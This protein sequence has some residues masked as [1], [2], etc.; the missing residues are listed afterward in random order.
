MKISTQNHKRGVPM[1][2]QIELNFGETRI[3]AHFSLFLRVSTILPCHSRF[4][5]QNAY[6]LRKS[7][8]LENLPHHFNPIKTCIASRQN[9]WDNMCPVQP[10]LDTDT[11]EEEQC[12]RFEKAVQRET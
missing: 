9:V 10:L 5:L 3:S 8:Q 2:I 6:T 1:H 12:R 11:N 4:H 7:L